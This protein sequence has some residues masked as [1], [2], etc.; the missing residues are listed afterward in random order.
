MES[1][2]TSMHK[3]WQ[4]FAVTESENPQGA[5]ETQAVYHQKAAHQWA[6]REVRDTG[7]LSGQIFLLKRRNRQDHPMDSLL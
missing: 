2:N 7:Q 5:K 6:T 4:S 1:S 3:P